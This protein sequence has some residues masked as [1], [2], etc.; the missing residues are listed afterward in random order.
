MKTKA[1]WLLAA[2][3]AVCVGILVAIPLY[4]NRDVVVGTRFAPIC[5]PDNGELVL[6]PNPDDCSTFFEC[7]N[8]VPV[9]MECPDG[10]YYCAEKMICDWM[11]D[12]DCSFNCVTKN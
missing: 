8:G 11:W 5:P 4:A 12:T 2:T 3:V 1:K 10:L 7:D 9:F 6:L